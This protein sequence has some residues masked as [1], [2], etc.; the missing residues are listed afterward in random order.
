MLFNITAGFI[1]EVQCSIFNFLFIW[2]QLYSIQSWQC[3][4]EN[5]DVF[6]NIKKENTL[7]QNSLMQKANHAGI[8]TCRPTSSRGNMHSQTLGHL[9]GSFCSQHA[10]LGASHWLISCLFFFPPPSLSP[11]P[12]L[13]PSPILLSICS[14]SQVLRRRWCLMAAPSRGCWSPHSYRSIINGKA[15][16]METPYL[17]TALLDTPCR[18]CTC[19]GVVRLRRACLW[20]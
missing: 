17:Q 5:M 19:W 10:Y 15:L 16:I 3:S 7:Q 18:G 9:Q 1:T 8:S 14:L 12:S 11:P 4:V 20:S 6:K 13:F 2:I